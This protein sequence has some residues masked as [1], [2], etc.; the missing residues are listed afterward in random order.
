MTL[1]H[2]SGPNIQIDLDCGNVTKHANTVK[3]NYVLR[4]LRT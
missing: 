3:I 2:D 4:Q 1:P